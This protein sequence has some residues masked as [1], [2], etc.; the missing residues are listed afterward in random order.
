MA[1]KRSGAWDDFRG[2]YSEGIGFPQIRGELCF[3]IH[4][5]YMPFAS[6]SLGDLGS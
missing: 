2:V 6:L 5:T 1:G 3:C 4:G